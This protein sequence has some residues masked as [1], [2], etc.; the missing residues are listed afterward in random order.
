MAQV[1]CKV[2][3]V[4]NLLPPKHQMSQYRKEWCYT[5]VLAS[6]SLY[7][8]YRNVEG[9]SFQYWQY[10]WIWDYCLPCNT[11][12]INICTDAQPLSIWRAYLMHQRFIDHFQINA[13]TNLGTPRDNNWTQTG[14][15]GN[16]F[17]FLLKDP[18]TPLHS[19]EYLQKYQLFLQKSIHLFYLCIQGWG[20]PGVL[21][22]QQSSCER[23][24]IPWT[25][26][27]SEP[28]WS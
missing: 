28:T 14:Y 15:N 22:F 8:K 21:F 2:S 10:L 16:R 4:S 17:V 26:S 6:K 11:M 12:L 13:K 5:V 1:N 25:D 24:G 3:G 19:V 20:V 23:Q 27:Q 18:Q 9:T 7:W